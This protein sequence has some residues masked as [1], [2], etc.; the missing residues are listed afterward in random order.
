[1]AISDLALLERWRQQGDADAFRMVASRHSGMVYATCRRIL[2]DPAEA[3]DAAQECFERLAR[4]SD[5]PRRNL[6]AWLHAVATNLARDR[7]KADARRKGREARYTAEKPASTEITQ[8]DIYAYVDEGIAALPEKLREPLV[9]HFLEDQSHASIA[10]ALGVSRQTVAYRIDRGL[11]RVRRSLKRRGIP[12]TASAF[13]AIMGTQMAEAAPVT[14]TATLGKLAIAS[15]QTVGTN[16]APILGGTAAIGGGIVMKKVVVLGIVVLLAATGGVIVVTQREDS[17]PPST[18]IPSTQ[19]ERSFVASSDDS[20]SV[21]QTARN[22]S[23]GLQASET[24]LAKN[25]PVEVTPE[26]VQSC[27]RRLVELGR[28]VIAWSNDHGGAYPEKFS[29]LYPDYVSD[30]TLFACPCVSRGKE[31]PIRP[32]NIDVASDYIFVNHSYSGQPPTHIV[33]VAHDKPENHGGKGCNILYLDGHVE[34]AETCPEKDTN[35]EPEQPESNDAGKGDLVIAGV[36]RDEAGTPIKGVFIQAFGGGGN[37]H[38]DTDADGAFRLVGLAEGLYTV[39]VQ[40]EKHTP[41]SLVGIAAGEEKLVVVLRDRAVVE[42]R[43]VDASTGRPLAEFGIQSVGGIQGKLSRSYADRFEIVRD[44]QGKFRL[45]NVQLGDSTIVVQADGFATG[46]VP[47]HR[48]SSAPVGRVEVALEPGLIAEGT[49]F[50]ETGEA[51]SGAW[52]FSGDLPPPIA[53]TALADGTMDAAGTAATYVDAVTSDEGQYTLNTLTPGDNRVSAFHPKAGR[54]E[55]ALSWSGKHL[56]GIDIVLAS[57][58]SGSVEVVV[59]VEGVPGKN[60]VVFA[61]QPGGLGEFVQRGHTN[62]DGRVLLED[63]PVG[64]VGITAVYPGQMNSYQRRIVVDTE[65]TAGTTQSLLINFETPSATIDGVVTLDGATPIG[66]NIILSMVRSGEMERYVADFA[67]EGAFHIAD[68]V[69]GTGCLHLNVYFEGGNPRTKSIDLEIA[70]GEQK[71]LDIDLS[72]GATISGVVMGLGATEH[73]TV[74]VFRGRHEFTEISLATFTKLQSFAAGVGIVDPTGAYVM[75][76]LE[77]GVYTLVALA[78]K[79]RGPDA[80]DD[81]LWATTQVEVSE[82]GLSG[83]DF[84]MR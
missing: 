38:T 59:T 45:E 35:P 63:L 30:L 10:E 49:V 33:K 43:V 41:E 52:V 77:P 7:V 54:G 46:Y 23:E 24:R 28:A 8:D 48:E 76:G 16:T 12:V 18:V 26:L 42:G 56:T 78:T 83:V 80:F 82:E 79:T 31:E 60:S 73:G 15:I 27:A 13:A 6:G 37:P 68:V 53:L 34:F 72:G 57:D 67:E 5:Q 50:D 81:A 19:D 3:E 66:G 20:S 75:E 14:L 44:P 2:R 51:V 17:A 47:L 29:D 55:A 84:D 4:H 40:D 69:P 9:A 11:E 74:A 70:E 65:V 25:A 32:E 36:V 58:A 71:H 61:G 22:A 64:L 39:R 62:E 1:M 21:G